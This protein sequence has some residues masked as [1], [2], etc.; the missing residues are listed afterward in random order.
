LTTLR[1]EISVLVTGVSQRRPTLKKRAFHALTPAWLCP[2]AA[3]GLSLI[4]IQAID[5]AGR[6]DPSSPTNPAALKQTIFLGIGMLAGAAIA[7]PHPRMVGRLAGTGALA[8]LALLIMLLVPAVP[9]SLVTARNGARAWIN[10]GVVDLQP[11][12]LAKV[13]YVLLVARYLRYR[14]EHRELSGLVPLG[15]LTAIPVGLITLQPDLGTAV[16][17]IP[18]L[19]GMLLAAGA[20]IRH[21]VLITTVSAI[22][23]PAVYPALQPHQKQRLVALAHQIRGDESLDSDANYQ[24]VV[25]QRLAGAGGLTGVGDRHARSLVYFNRLPEAHNDMVFAVIT[26]RDGLLGAMSLMALALLWVAGALWTAGTTRDPMGRLVTVGLAAFIAAQTVINIGM[27]IGL[28]PIIGITLPFVSYGG[29]SMVVCWLMTGLVLSAGLHRPR[30]PFRP[31]F[32]F[33]D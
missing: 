32:E 3:L 1:E 16:L 5:V 30:P 24:P 15:L 25:A 21:L 2:L 7:L 13:V 20:R 26:N 12:E 6:I 19:F 9:E 4:G 31:S 10:L 33:D 8:V 17:F 28:L 22:A 23:A 29:S 11:S 27:N 18:S 14:Q